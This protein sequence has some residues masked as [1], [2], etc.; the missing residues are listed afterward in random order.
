MLTTVAVGTDGSETADR[1]VDFAI[2]M[3]QRY[4]AGLVVASCYRPVSEARVKEEQKDAPQEIMWSINPT[5]NV[6]A[7]LRSAEEKAKALGLKTVSDA[8]M[9]DPADVLCEIAEE[10]GADVL[11]VGNRGMHRRVLGSVPNTVS[12]RAPCSVVIVKTA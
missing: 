4:D 10:H 11:I 7:T 12:H 9:G 6:E 2:D 1:A 3:A 8:R 5:E